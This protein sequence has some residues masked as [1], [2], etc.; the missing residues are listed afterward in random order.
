MTRWQTRFTL[1]PPHDLAIR[2]GPSDRQHLGNVIQHRTAFSACNSINGH[3]KMIKGSSMWL[4][5]IQI[6]S[7]LQLMPILLVRIDDG[8]AGYWSQQH[9]HQTMALFVIA[10]IHVPSSQQQ[11]L[12]PY[13]LDQLPQGWGNHSASHFGVKN[14][15]ILGWVHSQQIR[16]WH[17]PKP[18]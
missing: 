4:D 16:P 14:L 7:L 3:Y 8:K 6:L 12:V 13:C 10:L 11:A 1:N 2:S 5:S 9:I 15:P 18:Y 17:I